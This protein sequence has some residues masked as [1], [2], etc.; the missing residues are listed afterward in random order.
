MHDFLE[1]IQVTVIRNDQDSCVALDTNVAVSC[2]PGVPSAATRKHRGDMRF[3]LTGLAP[4]LREKS[5]H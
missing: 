4:K 2:A 5:A 3:A 1:L